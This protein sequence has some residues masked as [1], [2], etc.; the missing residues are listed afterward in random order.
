MELFQNITNCQEVNIDACT[1]V[2]RIAIIL[3]TFNQIIDNKND[4]FEKMI[5]HLFVNNN[6]TNTQL[7]NDFH[8]IKYDHAV[9]FDEYKFADVY[10]Y[11]NR[12]TDKICPMKRCH[13]IQRHYRDRTQLMDEYNLND[14]NSKYTFE[15]MSRMHVYFVHSYDTNKLTLKE[16]DNI[17]EQLKLLQSVQLDSE[18][19][20]PDEFKHNHLQDKKFEM[21]TRYLNKKAKR[22]IVLRN[23]DRNIENK[24][25]EEQVIN[26]I[27][28]EQICNVLK[29]NNV[30]TDAKQIQNV[31]VKYKN[32]KNKF[33]NDVIDACYC[34]NSQELELSNKLSK[35]FLDLNEQN[36][37][38]IYQ[39][40]LYKYV[41]KQ[42]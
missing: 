17:N 14:M 39:T 33:I 41:Q 18:D 3:G 40:I 31:V 23:R 13:H 19:D 20:Y 28:D 9:D 36:K 32:D 4:E 27:D 25:D 11:M 6:Y 22:L 30:L 26:T 24:T 10:N 12:N 42:E 21:V 15:L 2:K 5:N 34:A 37:L 29:N 38:L 35:C 7:L 8:H 16:L 1:S